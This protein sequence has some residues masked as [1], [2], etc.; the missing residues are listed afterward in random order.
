LEGISGAEERKEEKKMERE[1][2]RKLAGANLEW[3]NKECDLI[4]V[5]FS[6][7]LFLIVVF[8]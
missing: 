4:A 6:V 3:K 1:T 7:V 8:I 2:L 5:G